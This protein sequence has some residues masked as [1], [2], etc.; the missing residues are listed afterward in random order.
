MGVFSCF[1]AGTFASSTE[2]YHD[3]GV[4]NPLG[5]LLPRARDNETDAV[6]EPKTTYLPH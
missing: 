5:L 6:P 2:V 3:S 4:R 1:P